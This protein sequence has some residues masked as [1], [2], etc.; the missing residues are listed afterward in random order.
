MRGTGCTRCEGRGLGRAAANQC[1]VP[2]WKEALGPAEER[3]AAAGE[4]S[5]RRET[6]SL[7]EGAG[8]SVAPCMLAFVPTDLHGSAGRQLLVGPNSCLQ[9]SS[10]SPS[11]I[12]PLSNA[13]EAVLTTFVGWQSAPVNQLT[14]RSTC[15]KAAKKAIAKA[16]KIAARRKK[17]RKRPISSPIGGC[18]GCASFHCEDVALEKREGRAG[19]ADVVKRKAT[20]WS[21]DHFKKSR[22][23][24]WQ[25]FRH[26]GHP[27]RLVRAKR[28]D[29]SGR[30]YCR[31]TPPSRD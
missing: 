4:C 6:S 11:L 20:G 29:A 15:C 28:C 23:S 31:S 21:V 19:M 1:W 14:N 13:L 30:L 3:T 18:E 24:E 27:V 8:H 25:I 2:P 26:G 22:V 16:K 7:A 12:L 5:T 10:L 17:P 9:S